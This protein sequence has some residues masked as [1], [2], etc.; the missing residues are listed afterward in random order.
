MEVWCAMAANSTLPGSVYSVLHIWVTLRD[1][2][3][4]LF[5]WTFMSGM[6]S[7]TSMYCLWKSPGHSDYGPHWPSHTVYP[8]QAA[9]EGAY[10]WG[11]IQGQVEVPWLPKDPHLQRLEIY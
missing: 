2:R 10:D 11:P 7:Q 8:H 6:L 5:R 9:E 1:P 4:S 3:D